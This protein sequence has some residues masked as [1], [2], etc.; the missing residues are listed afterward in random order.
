MADSFPRQKAR[1]RNFTLGA[2]RSFAVAADGSRV[3]FLR[4]PAGDDP[5]TALW[6]LDLA[7]GRERLVADPA[8]LVAGASGEDLSIAERARRERARETA[9]GIVAYATDRDAQV[10]ALVQSGRLFVADLLAGGV[11]ELDVPTP[12]FDPRPDPSGRQVA[13]V[14]ERALHVVRISDGEVTRLAGE[15]A[16]TVSWGTAEFIAAEEMERGRGYWWSPDGDALLVTRVDESPV[17]ELWITDAADPGSPPRA[18]RYPVAGSPNA[19]VNAHLV[20]L[21]GGAALAVQWDRTR[22]PYLAAGH[23]DEHGP[24]IAVQTRD[25]RELT[26]L[27]V[28]PL[29]G[30]TWSLSTQSDENWVDLI[31]GVPR[32]L[33]DGRLVTVAGQDDALS[34]FIGG[35]PVTPPELEVRTVLG[36][37]GENVLF[38]ASTDATE[39]QVWRWESTGALTPL[40]SAPG[41]HTAVAGGSVCVV[42]SAAIEHDGTRWSVRD[43]VFATHASAPIVRPA[44]QLLA[45][46]DRGLRVGL[47]LPR[48]HE[49]G[50]R[51]PVLMDPYGGPHFQRVVAARSYWLE[52]QWLAN[53]GFAVIVADGRGTPGRG[54][55]WARA[56]HGD[57]AGPVLEDQIDALA[58]VAAG[59]RDLDLGRVAIRGWSFGGYLAALA[60]LRRPDVF[61]A[62]VAGAPVTE[63]RL[64][65]THYTERYLGV[66]P[67]GVDRPAYA[68]SSL[69]DDAAALRRPLLLIH[70]L[71]DDNVV[72]AHTLQLSQRLTESGRLHTVLPLTG[73]THMTPQDAVA[74]NLLT[75]Q[76]DFLRGALGAVTHAGLAPS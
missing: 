20:R 38:A 7:E 59:H 67:D 4:S 10:A 15:A 16:A 34:L 31:G 41:V 61:H 42:G 76:V 53:Q 32:R 27:A 9:G 51:L 65:D 75:L 68:G 64:Y 36:T 2:P 29:T 49:R 23:W 71:A 21:D 69:L 48:D 45:V 54:R 52:S 24:L 14:H 56:V 57:L 66:D 62:A 70:G 6:A 5:R 1:T 44:L 22:H 47:L 28:D 19:S 72:A 18:V 17:G 33:A 8:D 46:G 55:A 37:A 73:V 50:S 43:H 39:V 26:V 35:T 13:F 58:E 74:E 25:Q 3:V 40:T 63:W 11:R 12:V 30:A 60:V